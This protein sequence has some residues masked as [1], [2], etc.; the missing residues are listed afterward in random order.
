MTSKDPLVENLSE[1]ETEVLQLVAAGFSNRQIA[2]ELF[3]A[4][5]TV[6]T[7]I[8]NI[9][10]KLDVSSR[11]QAIA[12]ASHLG[13]LEDLSSYE[14]PV[15]IDEDDINNPYKGLRAFQ[16]D[17]AGDFFGRDM[18]IERLLDRFGEESPLNRFLAV[19]GPSG[20]GKSS[21]VKAGLLP[22]LR[23]GK[24]TGS[25]SWLIAEMLP[26]THPIEEL[27]VALNQLATKPILDLANHIRQNKRGLSQVARIL[28][29]DQS[30]L[31]LVIDQFEEVFTLA[32]DT[33]QARHFLDAI[34]ASVLNERS[35]FRI[36]I[37]LRADFYDRP[38]M[39]PDFSEL[40]RLRTE[41]VTPL[42]ANEIEQAIIGP[43]EKLGIRAE[44]GLVTRIVAD[45]NE[46]PGALP[47]LQYAL[48]ELFDHRI[49]HTLTQ[50]VYRQIGGTLGALARH[51]DEVFA[52]LTPVQ[53]EGTRQMFLRLITLGEGTEDTRRR[54]LRSELISINED[55][56]PI[57]VDA[58]DESRLLT[59]D[60]DPVTKEPTVEV[61]HEAIIRE[62]GR[63]RIWLDES[64]NEIRQQRLLQHS[65]EQWI[66]ANRDTSYL[67]RGA[68]LEQF[69]AWVEETTLIM[70]ANEEA[71]LQASIAERERQLHRE[72]ERA[73]HEAA[74]ER[75]SRT[76]LRALLVVFLVAALIAGGLALFAF[77]ERS[78]AQD[79]RDNEA[80]A[81]ANSEVSARQSQALFLAAEAEQALDDGD[82]DLAL[83]LVLEAYR[84][85]PNVTGVKRTLSSVASAGGTQSI[86]AR[87]EGEIGDI[88]LSQD[89]RL[90]AVA[91]FYNGTVS[92]WDLDSRQKLNEWQ[93]FR[94]NS[95]Q[96]LLIDQIDINSDNSL[97]AVGGAFIGSGGQVRLID[98]DSGVVEALPSLPNTI[99]DVRFSRDGEHLATITSNAVVSV[100]DVSARE[101]L[102]QVHEQFVMNDSRL[103]GHSIAFSPDGQT[104]S[105]TLSTNRGSVSS[106]MAAIRDVHNFEL[107]RLDVIEP[108]DGPLIVS[109]DGRYFIFD[110]FLDEDTRFLRYIDVATGRVVNEIKYSPELESAREV[111]SFFGAI[112]DNRVLNRNGQEILLVDIKSGTILA[113]FKGHRS[114]VSASLFLDTTHIIS[115]SGGFGDSV[116]DLNV[117]VWDA[118][119]GKT[120]HVFAGKSVLIPEGNLVLSGFPSIPFDPENPPDAISLYLVDVASGKRVRDFSFDIDG[121]PYNAIFSPDGRRVAVAA[122][123]PAVRR[124][125][126]TIFT[127]PALQPISQF[128][129][130]N[131]DPNP[132][133]S[134]DG[135]HFVTGGDRLDN[136]F[137]NY[138]AQVWDASTGQ[139]V[140]R[141]NQR[142]PVEFALDLTSENRMLAGGANDSTIRVI[143]Y[144]NQ[145][146]DE[147]WALH[148]G[149]VIRGTL[150]RDQT[151]LLT[152]DNLGTII[153]SD[154][155][156][157]EP[158]RTYNFRDAEIHSLVFAPDGRRAAAGDRWGQIMIWDLKTGDLLHVVDSNGWPTERLEFTPDG[159]YLISSSSNA[160]TRVW[161]VPPYTSIEEMVSWLQNN[162]YIREFTCEE[163]FEFNIQPMCDEGVLPATHTP[164]LSLT[165]SSTPTVTLTPDFNQTTATP[166]NTPTITPTPY[167]TRPTLTPM[168]FVSNRVDKGAMTSGERVFNV[169]LPNDVHVWTLASTAGQD[170]S[171]NLSGFG[172]KMTL[173]AV[174]G[175]GLIEAN[176]NLKTTVT[177]PAAGNYQII[178]E[179][180]TYANSFYTL[181][182]SFQE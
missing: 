113:D 44:P 144:V 119:I 165:P 69:E 64:R 63:L 79:A 71:F 175:R 45:V 131:Y 157:Q 164:A 13:L 178:L 125:E 154:P 120:K 85:A 74:L 138:V 141:N 159:T 43:I 65:A 86:F 151:R 33:E 25:E 51:A 108:G 109:Q 34:H 58:F 177:L 9:Y 105:Y 156:L 24:I 121:L 27:A 99:R 123:D 16:E 162:R 174:N 166:T 146:L 128:G 116:V 149:V 122:Y 72:A 39:F 5:G 6:K 140:H 7:H 50:T 3:L 38:L 161:R 91:T 48:T 28:F 135:M 101:L 21:V 182:V 4:L 171:I 77:D 73:A 152:G 172:V 29:P 32:E 104:L 180:T 143:D 168:E 15:Y 147:A 153:L 158:K 8:H 103:L 132:S 52:V 62:W 133:F 31:L 139:V 84:L 1:R 55:V 87:F 78:A 127:W 112:A 61:A 47:L 2:R 81:R 88:A 54:A 176:D 93:I 102:L 150:N 90:L 160:E 117:R 57:V 114:G 36:L 41:V 12:R 148:E 83:A 82:T 49:N 60:Y 67:L 170:I 94:Q 30:D 53:Q 137:A 10:S 130:A 68:R 66:T 89:R 124:T 173:L 110:Q 155:V 76:I 129:V 163:R 19:V 56:M 167:P 97:I 23:S 70:A 14:L 59:F 40:I 107:I 17:D 169:I 37:T 42:T 98:L 115:A 75:R 92:L 179:P 111:D 181:I 11:T 118:T 80:T 100:W 46:Q 26:G 142:G 136:T 134:A 106:W 95:S 18:L 145:Q 126:Y 96:N 22:A 35:P 20:S